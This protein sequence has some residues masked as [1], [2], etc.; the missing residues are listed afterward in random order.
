MLKKLLPFL[1]C[2][3][4]ALSLTAC[5]P[6]ESAAQPED[7]LTL[8]ATTY[9]VY[10]FTR[11]VTKGAD[12]VTVTLMVN[13]SVSC[14]HDYTLSVR[15]MK[16]L[17]RADVVI[18]NGAG[19]EDSMADAL[20]AAQTR[21]IDCSAGIELLAASHDHDHDHGHGERETHDHEALHDDHADHDHSE[22]EHTGEA[23]P[24][25]WMDPMRACQMLKNLAA[26]LGAL[27]PDQAALYEANAQAA[28][29]QVAA[30]YRDLRPLLDDLSC[31]ELIPFHDGF[32]YFAEAFDLT[33]LRS[34]EEEAG[35]EASARDVIEILDEI[36]LHHL[37]AIF[38]ETNGSTATAQVIHRENGVPVYALDML[39]SGETESVGIDTYLAGIT[40][41]VKTI[42]EACS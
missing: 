3:T 25:I 24:H 13:Q 18:L 7:G 29:E 26:G 6:R 2:L 9:P 8:A 33:I 4:L 34:I 21:Q 38:T 20:D 42:Q 39:M 28:A 36:S 10:L 41:N 11:E 37:P 32:T 1:F 22:D 35:S 31:R 19:L 12:N 30:A 40:A 15:D 27:D 5:G 14:L 17:D 16:V 23:D